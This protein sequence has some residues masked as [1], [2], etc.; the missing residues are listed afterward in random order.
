MKKTF[1]PKI[2]FVCFCLCL[3]SVR[4]EHAD[5]RLV[6]AALSKNIHVVKRL[7]RAGANPDSKNASGIRPLA[8][9]IWGGD[10]RVVALFIAAGANL[11]ALGVNRSLALIEAVLAERADL[12]TQLLSAG[13]DPRIPGL[14]GWSALKVAERKGFED[15]AC[16]LRRAIALRQ[17]AEQSGT[18]KEGIGTR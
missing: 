18:I 3:T 4:A 10:S 9:A 5:D 1:A 2:A 16:Q 11:D 13:A 7:L 8:A 14:Y 6:T 15:L 17:V 12:V